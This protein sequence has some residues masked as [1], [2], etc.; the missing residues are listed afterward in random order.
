MWNVRIKRMLTVVFNGKE[1]IDEAYSKD[2][3]NSNEKTLF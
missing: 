2:A 3:N 1:I